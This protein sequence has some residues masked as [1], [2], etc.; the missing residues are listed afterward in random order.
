MSKV[1]HDVQC[2]RDVHDGRGFAGGDPG[3]L[4]L[5]GRPET[6]RALRPVSALPDERAG[7][8]DRRRG[9]AD[10]GHT[11]S[12]G[13]RKGRSMR[14]AVQY[15]MLAG[16]LLLGVSPAAGGDDKKGKKLDVFWTSPE[17]AN[18]RLRSVAMLPAGTYD[19]DYK[20][21]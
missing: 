21:E 17:T 7:G 16:A 14:T 20:A 12:P 8:E 4:P 11:L 6:G 3:G 15:T 18:L 5:P 13:H 10:A 19:N 9:R 1:R 2:R